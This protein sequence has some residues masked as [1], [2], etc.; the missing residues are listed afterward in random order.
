[1]AFKDIRKQQFNKHQRVN[2][3][4]RSMWPMRLAGV[5]L[6]LFVLLAG[7]YGFP[8]VWNDTVGQIPG[9]SMHARDFRLG[10]DLL[11]GTHLVYEADLTEIPLTERDTS[12]EGVRDVIERRVNAFGVAEPV[13]QTT[14]AGDAFR[15]IVELAG[16]SDVNEAIKQIGETPIL[17]FKRPDFGEI[18]ISVVSEEE[19]VEEVATLEEQNEEIEREA[20]SLLSRA[21]GGEDFSVLVA[22]HSVG[23]QVEQEGVSAWLDDRD[24]RFEFMALPGTPVGTIA[25]TVYEKEDYY[26]VLRV[27][28]ERDANEWEYRQ[29]VVCHR[30]VQGCPD[31]SPRK[32]KAQKQ[33]LALK[34]QADDLGFDTMLS[35]SGL[36]GE[37]R[38]WTRQNIMDVN[39]AAAL[40]QM[41]VGEVGMIEALNG[42][43]IVELTGHR[44][45]PEYKLQEIDLAKAVQ[46]YEP[47]TTGSPD[48][49]ASTELGGAQLKRASVEFDPNTG[50]PYVTLTFD[51]E[52]GDL[53]AAI[54]EAHVGQQIAIFLDGEAISAPVVQQ[55]IYGGEAVIT[56]I[57]DLVEAR[58]LAQR[59]NAGALPVPIELIS[60]QT[61]GPTLGAVS[62]DRSLNAAF[63]GLILVALFMI[64]Y[65]RL[66]GLISV[67]ALGVY[68]ILVLALFKF[69]PVTL[70]LAG[71]AGFILS[72]GMAVDA[73]V[74]IFERL[75][76]EMDAGR[77]L[78]RSIEEGFKRAWT[79][80]RDGNFTTLIACAILYWFSSS[81]I[82]GF[83]LTLAVGILVSMFTAITVTRA[84]LL[85]LSR[86]NK[87]NSAFM[88]SVKEL[89][90]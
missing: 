7:G 27:H 46:T 14:K 74:L 33:A 73:N 65:Y 88:Y 22:G 50:I 72:V 8:G 38:P 13:V 19:Q 64:L 40:V 1:M 63:I 35:E 36:S 51:K 87:I 85:G 20:R 17:E 12:L 9:L 41:D 48:G 6:A 5:A 45:Y 68:A 44:T 16:I 58:L 24:D 52:G 2:V 83:A 90:K 3:S 61:V 60:Q 11:G 10:L 49:W 77:N 54:T 67:L 42:Y 37:D 81:F 18:D 84:V 76:E 4:K 53:F 75:K 69:I 28:D 23:P 79:S 15:V 59:L 57:G 78:H 86:F 34:V 31:N 30:E 32:N 21:R 66:P 43:V 62:L 26:S 47:N 29:V 56:G 82:Q 80:I 39:I 89:R 71:L 25:R 55:A 70:T